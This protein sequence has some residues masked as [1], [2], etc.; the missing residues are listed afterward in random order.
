MEMQQGDVS[1][2][3]GVVVGSMK[4]RGTLIRCE[5][6]SRDALGIVKAWKGRKDGNG[7]GW[8]IHVRRF[9]QMHRLEKQTVTLMMFRLRQMGAKVTVE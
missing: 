5:E 8:V 1:N 9:A 3:G 7:K 2:A 4:H 6:L